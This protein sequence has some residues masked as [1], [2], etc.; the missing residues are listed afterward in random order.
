MW[1]RSGCQSYVAIYIQAVQGKECNWSVV[2]AQEENVIN[3]VALADQLRSSHKEYQRRQRG[4]FIKQVPFHSL[5]TL[6]RHIDDFQLQM[7]DSIC[8]LNVTS[9][10]CHA[11]DLL[12]PG[13]GMRNDMANASQ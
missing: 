8:D 7:I 12:D 13:T 11:G 3:V 9:A 6:E 5:T 2:H 4:P 1:P 10:S